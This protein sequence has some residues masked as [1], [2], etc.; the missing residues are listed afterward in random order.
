MAASPLPKIIRFPLNG[1]LPLDKPA[2]FSSNNVLIKAKNLLCA[3]KA[4]HTGT[5]DPFATGILILCFGEATKFSQHLLDSDKTYEALV[6][7]GVST[8]SGDIEGEVKSRR[9]CNVTF[10]QIETALEKFRGPITQIPPMYSALKYNGKPLY[11]YARAGI[12][13][14]RPVRNVTI[15]ALELLEYQAPLLRLRITCSKG[16]Y[17]RVLSEDIGTSLGC[18]AHLQE[19][20]RT[21][22]GHLNLDSC[23]T[24]QH[25]DIT[26]KDTRKSL[27]HPIDSLLSFLPDISLPELLAVRFLQGQRINLSQESSYLGENL[28]KVRVYQQC[29]DNKKLLG[30]AQLSEYGILSPERLINT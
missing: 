10:S 19:L 3:K 11:K 2:G 6:F 14:E 17:I 9:D 15:H 28:K 27:L 5:L 7:M 18:G 13:L 12:T 30:T 20:R 4:G 29:V 1:I 25:L 24:M 22:I 26:A 23:V 16:T 21:K 8:V